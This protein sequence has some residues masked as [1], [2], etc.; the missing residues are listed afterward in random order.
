MCNGGH[1]S[2]TKT[3]AQSI[4]KRMGYVKRRASTKAKVTVANFDAQKALFLHDVKSIIVME[5]IPPQLVINWDH[6]GIN[7]VLVS[8]WTM[9]KEGSKRIEIFGKDDKRQITAVFGGTMSG[10]FLY[11][12]ILYAGKTP[13]CLPSVKFPE[14]WHITYTENHWAN[15]K[16]TADYI[17][18]ILLPYIERK[19]TELSLDS[20]QP[21]LVIFDRFKGQCTDQILKLLDDNN[22]RIAVVPANCTDRLQPLDV[23]VNKS[24]K[25][26]LRQ[27]FQTWYS[28]QVCS[29]LDQKETT[30][31]ISPVSIQMSVVKPLGA[32]WLISLFE[33]MISK[34]EIMINGF[35]YL[36]CLSMIHYY[37]TNS[38][39]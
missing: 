26:Y 32:N 25:D 16:T 2:L 24:V 7:F 8:N 13:R 38:K 10:E 3:W 31:K 11:P 39:K 12:Q 18:L 28:D 1:I 37:C 29:Q 15:E 4:L 6:T 20:T 5:E 33:Y 34:P 36:I 35:N 27:Q 17:R 23:S 21:A 19:R 22:I 30:M 9:A 14:G